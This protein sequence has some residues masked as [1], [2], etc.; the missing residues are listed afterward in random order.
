MSNINVCGLVYREKGEARGKKKRLV[1][2]TYVHR[3]IGGPKRDR[4]GVLYET[5]IISSNQ[6]RIL[7]KIKIKIVKQGI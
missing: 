2:R 1:Q 7:S 4:P 3:Q 6:N 5:I